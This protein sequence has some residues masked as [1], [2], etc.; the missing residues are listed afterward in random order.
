MQ[1]RKSSDRGGQD[2]WMD[3]SNKHRAFTQET[4][5]LIPHGYVEDMFSPV[6]VCWLVGGFVSRVTQKLLTGFLQNL[7]GRWVSDQN[8]PH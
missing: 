8:R 5:L 2:A 6:S 4:A 7:D 3:G 1:K